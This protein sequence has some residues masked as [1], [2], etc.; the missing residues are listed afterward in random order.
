MLAKNKRPY[1][2]E[3]LPPSTRL[4]S[5]LGDLLSRN[6]L[7][8]TRIAEI[9]NDINRVAPTELRALTGPLNT[10][11]A[12][13]LRRKFLKKSTWMPDYIADVRTWNTKT[14]KV[15]RE[16]VPMQ[17]I[18]EVVAVLLKYGFKDKLLKTD[19]MDPLTLEHLRHCEIEAGCDLLGMGLWGDGAPTQWDLSLIHI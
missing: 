15:V 14:Q 19:H 1:D 17:L 10:N 4:R 9:A 12:R 2:P 7:P 16:K 18:H 3:S 11:T 13:K 8:A 5:N 6:E